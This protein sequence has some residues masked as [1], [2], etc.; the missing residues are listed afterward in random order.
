MSAPPRSPGGLP[1]PEGLSRH[2]DDRLVAGVCAGI[3]RWLGVDPTIVRIAAVLLAFANGVGVLVYLVAALVLPEDP[4]PAPDGEAGPA[5][6]PAIPATPAAAGGASPHRQN[7]EHALAL[8]CI[9]LGMLLLVRSVSPFFPDHLVWPATVAAGGLG[10][11][12]SRAGEVDRARWRE[13]VSRLPGDPLAALSGRGLWLRLYGGAVLLVAGIGWFIAANSTFAGLGQIGMAMLA[14]TL[15]LAVLLGPWT[16]GLVR[17]LR[18]ERHERIRTE[19]RADMAAHLHDSVLQTLA[20]IQRHADSP[21]QTRSLARRQERELRGWLFDAR[22]PGDAPAT[23]AAA[24]DRLSDDIESDHDVTVDVVVVGDCPFDERLD[25][26]VAAL[27]EAAVNAA[28]H[29]G[30]AEVSVYVELGDDEVEAFVRDRG[31]GFDRT[32][33]DRD[34]R[35]IADS[36]IGR[37]A[38]HGGSAKVR[39]TPGEGTEVSVRLPLDRDRREPDG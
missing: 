15:G 39:S 7:V 36:I 23:L 8:G 29:S 1:L 24:L 27:R 10:L 21:K 4:V 22:T 12:W 9:T 18:A 13:A 5:T 32:L 11:V 34:R 16:A 37:M 35:G 38:R 20:L 26:L 25:A 17:Q 31:K 28:R 2:R 14:T 6:D 3:A 19:E 33:V 30:E